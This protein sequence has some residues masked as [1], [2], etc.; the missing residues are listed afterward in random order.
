MGKSI[1][2]NQIRGFGSSFLARLIPFKKKEIIYFVSQLELDKLLFL[3][4]I[5]NY[6]V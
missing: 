5:V 1:S 4:E 6:N 3:V 2:A